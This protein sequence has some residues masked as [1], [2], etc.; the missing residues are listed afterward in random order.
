[1]PRRTVS[2]VVPLLFSALLL[3]SGCQSAGTLAFSRP[4]GSGAEGADA[5]ASP[6]TGAPGTLMSAQAFAEAFDAQIARSGRR[7]IAPDDTGGELTFRIDDI[8]LEAEFTQGFTLHVFAPGG[9]TESVTLQMPRAELKDEDSVP[10]GEESALSALREYNAARERERAAFMECAEAALRSINKY[11]QSLGEANV[12]LVLSDV[13]K[14]VKRGSEQS[15]ELPG[16]I[17]RSFVLDAD[18]TPRIVF[19]IEFIL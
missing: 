3:F 11:K 12:L 6:D 10:A 17:S 16:A 2:I 4:V 13:E 19:I 1:M 7:L 8:A 18:Y 15:E 14:T 9:D 5:E